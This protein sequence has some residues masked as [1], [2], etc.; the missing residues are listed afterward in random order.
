LFGK[1]ERLG[2]GT[3]VRLGRQIKFIAKVSLNDS[4]PPTPGGAEEKDFIQEFS[5]SP[6]SPSTD[7]GDGDRVIIL[8]TQSIQAFD[9]LPT[10]ELSPVTVGYESQGDGDNLSSNFVAVETIPV[11]QS[12]MVPEIEVEL[13][14]SP[15]NHQV[16][17][18]HDESLVAA[19]VKTVLE[20][21][22]YIDAIPKATS[23][24]IALA[25]T[26]PEITKGARVRVY[27]PGS[28]R[29]EKQGVIA[30][31]NYQHGI[32]W[33]V[34]VLEDIEDRLKQLLCPIPGNE[35]MKLELI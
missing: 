24:A 1:L 8:E 23:E 32:K 18:H 27:C 3:V 28:K 15:I 2:K 25:P 7:F 19:E 9:V 35:M 29:H 4:S 13:G 21:S 5:H 20:E 33:A 30:R 14:T 6:S 31:F 16:D 34:V 10:M 26:T 17:N 11:L 12:D 22:L